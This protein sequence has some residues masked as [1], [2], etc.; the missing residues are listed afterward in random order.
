MEPSVI[1]LVTIGLWPPVSVVAGLLIGRGISALRSDEP[2]LAQGFQASSP[3]HSLA[4]LK[5]QFLGHERPPIDGGWIPHSAAD[6]V[7][8][9]VASRARVAGGLMPVP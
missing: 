8:H 9:R 4:F 7:D 3:S 5:A 2:T 1:A 6:G